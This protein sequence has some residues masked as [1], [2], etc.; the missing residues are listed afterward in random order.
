MKPYV[1]SKEYGTQYDFWI[2][3]FVKPCQCRQNFTG[4]S[5]GLLSPTLLKL[6]FFKKNGGTTRPGYKKLNMA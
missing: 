1:L 3:K 2:Q 5:G 4:I 6:I